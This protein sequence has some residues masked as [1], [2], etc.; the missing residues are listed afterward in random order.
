MIQSLFNY[1]HERVLRFVRYY[2]SIEFLHFLLRQNQVVKISY[3][4]QNQSAV[5]LLWSYSMLTSL[6]KVTV[7][8]VVLKLV[9][10]Y[11]E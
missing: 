3:L 9:W 7:P 1:L 11:Y 4:K 2:S 5:A 8:V 10:F 6:K